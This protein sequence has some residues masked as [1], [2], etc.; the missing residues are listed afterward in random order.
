M[1]IGGQL[2]N[3]KMLNSSHNDKFYPSGFS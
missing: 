3:K 1:E 2:E